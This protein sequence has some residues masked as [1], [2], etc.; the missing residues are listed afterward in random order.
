MSARHETFLKIFLTGLLLLLISSVIFLSLVPP[1]SKDA[2]VH[3]LAVPEL[4]LKH[5]NIFE[6]P[7]MPYSYYPM[8][9][10]LLYLIA[11]Y[12][13]NDIAPKFIHFSFA[14]LTALLIYHYLKTRS[15]K[16]YALLGA[17]LF[18]SLPVVI[19]L[20]ITA[21]VDLGLTFFSTASVLLI[22]KWIQ[23]EFK[24]KFLILSALCC[25][26]GLG[27]KYNGIAVLVFLTLFVLFIHARFS[28]SGKFGFAKSLW[29]GALFLSIALLIFSPWMIRNY[30]WTNNPFYPLYE[31]RF[32]AGSTFPG[33][34]IDRR[35]ASLAHPKGHFAY[36]SIIY[37]EKWWQIAL[38]PVRIFF[39]GKDGDP[40]LF[41]GRLN[42]FL[43]IFPML[44]FIRVKRGPPGLEREKK[45]L[46]AF[47]ILILLFS[48]FGTVMRI[49]YLSPLIGPLIILSTLGIERSVTS[50]KAVKSVRW[51]T[52]RS[53]P[54]IFAVVFSLLLNLFYVLDQFKYV[55]PFSYISGKTD[56]DEYIT[57]YRPEYP[58]IQYANRN[59]PE[60]SL[61]LFVFLG[62][63]G[64]YC[65]RDYIPD[66]PAE[67][68]WLYRQVKSAGGDSQRLLERLRHRDIT[69]IIAHLGFLNKWSNDLFEEGG[70]R[71]L[72]D[73]FKGEL[74]LM[75]LDNE[76][77]VFEVSPRI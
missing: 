50:L 3:H 70:K 53:L 74:N 45:I 58:S 2:L 55:G 66:T 54:V 17:L 57:R 62:K 25:G 59:L 69:H 68:D 34:D 42:P 73:L 71:V 12:L 56:R 44:G 43:L 67:V 26:L 39:Q 61:I 41:D 51:K 15:D 6:I 75:F 38:V 33:S 47:S 60:H 23:K 37:K 52:S 9:L 1:V 5:G 28:G 7:S 65:K 10:D 36:R 11:L 16:I 14:L 40:R 49:R 22:L 63:R 76:I 19:K 77:G 21:Y 31:E 48:F 13:G 24:A 29:C 4:Y 18:L 72:K 27:T 64:Y 35:D 20:S 46:L 30:I 32:N 8:N